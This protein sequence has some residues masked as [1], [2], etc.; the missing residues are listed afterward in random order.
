MRVG[1][2]SSSAAD[3]SPPAAADW[4]EKWPKAVH[5]LAMAMLMKLLERK[6]MLR[7]LR[8]HY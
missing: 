3:S 4:K 1:S 7:Y 8:R 2:L 6:L 5:T